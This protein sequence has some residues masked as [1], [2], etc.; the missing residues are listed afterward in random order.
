MFEKNAEQF[1]RDIMENDDIRNRCIEI[2]SLP[3]DQRRSALHD[4]GYLFSAKELDDV[5]CKEFYS[6][7]LEKRCVFGNGDIR[8]II[9]AKW[10]NHM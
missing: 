9:M 1:F 8:D 7:P 2:S 5:V 10:G 3:E 6:I 4:L